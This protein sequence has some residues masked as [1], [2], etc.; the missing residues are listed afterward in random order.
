MTP[1]FKDCIGI[2][3]RGFRGLG[4][5]VGPWGRA[6][7][8][9]AKARGARGPELRAVSRRWERGIHGQKGGRR[10]GGSH[11]SSLRGLKGERGE[12]QR[13]RCG[14][15]GR[16]RG[17][18]GGRRGAGRSGG[19][20]RR[21]RGGARPGG[22]A[23]RIRLLDRSTGLPLRGCRI[24]GRPAPLPTFLGRRA[25]DG[26]GCPGVAP[27]LGSGGDD[28]GGGR[29]GRQLHDRPTSHRRLPQDLRLREGSARRGA[30]GDGG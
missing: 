15:G 25:G 21:G 2:G 17:R 9:G 20:G 24:T 7:E 23:R 30:G 8:A 19:R 26:A 6:L 4:G 11:G 10:A 13:G 18:E 5:V 16:E 1:P 28:V 12:G 27:T 3:F 14:R 22:T 29:G